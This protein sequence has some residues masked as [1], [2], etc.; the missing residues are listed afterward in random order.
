MKQK[1]KK[2]LLLIGGLCVLA[3]ILTR[4]FIGDT[5]PQ[6][7]YLKPDTKQG[8]NQLVVVL[9]AFTNS[10]DDMKDVIEVIESIY[11]TADIS[12]PNYHSSTLSNADLTWSG[13]DG[14]PS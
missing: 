7:S 9:H 11:S 2:S 13:P 14:H 8:S 6:I 12:A 4:I 5:S 1:M 10:R 3:V